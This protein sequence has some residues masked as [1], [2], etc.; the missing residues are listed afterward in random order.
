MEELRAWVDHSIQSV[1]DEETDDRMKEMD[2]NSDGFV[3]FKNI[4]I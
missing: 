1:D 2:I 3:S 4:D